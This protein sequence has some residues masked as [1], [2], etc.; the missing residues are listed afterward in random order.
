ML[1][2]KKMDRE[3]NQEEVTQWLR[4][5]RGHPYNPASGF[6]VTAVFR[7]KFRG[8]ATYYFAGV[9]V[10]NPHLRL[11]THAEE[12]CIAAMATAFGK[13]AE[14]VEGWVMGAPNTV[15]PGDGSPMA[16]I[17]VTCCG[18]CRQQI[19]GLA[20]PDVVMHSISLNGAHQPTTVG[21]FLPD[22]FTFKQFAPDALQPSYVG[23]LVESDIHNR[24]VREKDLSESDIFN[25]LK[26][27]EGIDHATQ[28]SQAVILKLTGNRYVAGVSI[29]EAAY[30]SIEPIQSAIAIANT[31]YGKSV[32]VEAV[33]TLSKSKKQ[34]QANTSSSEFPLLD[35]YK[36]K[37]QQPLDHSFTP[38]PL[39]SI[40]VLAQFSVDQNIP[41]HMFNES[42]EKQV[43]PLNESA[44]CIPTF[45]QPLPA[46]STE[47]RLKK[48][49]N[50][51]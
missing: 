33:W 40:Q 37:S 45:A 8:K 16:D 43:I 13:G 29:E 32:N 46:V 48:L 20:E 11:S 41:I 12:G 35:V 30:V 4:E 7:V 47:S 36:M 26:S 10:E 22:V 6:D 15:K 9:N 49:Q 3:L 17:Q 24:L 42:G 18:K 44:K 51:N 39:S 2:F 1:L 25:W 23:A 31:L 34:L 27:L 19:A 50:I 5:L 14:I 21:T 28:T 38:L